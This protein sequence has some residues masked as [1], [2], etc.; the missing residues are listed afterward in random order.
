MQLTKHQTTRTAEL[1]AQLQKTCTKLTILRHGFGSRSNNEPHLHTP[2]SV[3]ADLRQ[4][5][6]LTSASPFLK[7]FTRPNTRGT[8]MS[9]H[10][11]TA[12]FFASRQE[13]HGPR[14]F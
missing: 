1:D 9:R 11:T 10:I 5:P 6:A 13:I 2:K 4:L 7:H 14:S 8:Q 3:A 12:S